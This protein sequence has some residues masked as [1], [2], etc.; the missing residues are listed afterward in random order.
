MG[1]FIKWFTIALISVTIL[2]LILVLIGM[3]LSNQIAKQNL[4]SAPKPT[5]LIQTTQAPTPNPT[6]SR[7][8][9][10]GNINSV[11]QRVEYKNSMLIKVDFTNIYVAADTKITGENGKILSKSA[12]KKGSS[13]IVNGF[14]AEGGL[15]AETITVV[16]SS[17]IPTSSTVPPWEPISQP[18]TPSPS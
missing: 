9:V 5:P 6:T 1:M 13:V 7:M 14:P 3:T 4:P 2:I 15:E 10:A 11:I 12:L 16:G 8:Q 17:S 18:I